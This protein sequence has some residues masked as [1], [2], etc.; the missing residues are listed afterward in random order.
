MRWKPLDHS[1]QQPVRPFC[2]GNPS[3]EYP[4]VKGVGFILSKMA[5]DSLKE[6]E[7]V[8]PHII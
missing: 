8:S 7:P 1:G 4:H 5:A 6:W 2:T 3:E